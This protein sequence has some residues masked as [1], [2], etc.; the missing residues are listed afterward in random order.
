MLL[1]YV[2]VLIG[3][4]VVVYGV[5]GLLR[6]TS[7]KMPWRWSAVLTWSGLRGAIS[8]VLVLGLP[9]DF[10]HRELLVNMTFGVVVLSIIV[11]GLTMAPLLKRLGIT[12]L[13]D[14]YQEQYELARGRVGAVHADAQDG[15][16]HVET[17]C[18]Q[19]ALHAAHLVHQL[20]ADRQPEPPAKN[21][22]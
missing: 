22:G 4:A 20:V 16:R 7:E 15:S 12:G 9:N 14:I 5:S 8:M 13:K 11:Q 17:R 6:F 19:P 18:G 2:A 21:R 10:A 3:R 1:A